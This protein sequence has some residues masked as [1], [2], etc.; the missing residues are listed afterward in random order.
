MTSYNK[1][2]LKNYQV[3]TNLVV[4]LCP[5]L[6]VNF[7]PFTLYLDPFQHQFPQK[8]KSTNLVVSCKF[9]LLKHPTFAANQ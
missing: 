8:N 3:T 6:K 7:L 2:P 4:F 1:L 5:F 9:Y